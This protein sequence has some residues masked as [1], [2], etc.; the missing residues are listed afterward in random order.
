MEQAIRIQTLRNEE[1]KTYGEIEEDLGVSSKTIAKALLRPQEFV[2]GYQRQ[3]PVPRPVLGPFLEKI[4]E[5]LKGKDWAKE[6]GRK[7][8]RTARWVYRKIKKQGYE[9]AESTVRAYIREKF[10]KPRPACPIEHRP[11]DEVQF[12]F[13]QY[14]VRV[15]GSVQTI[16]FAGSVFPYSTR[17][18]LFAYPAERQECLFDAIERTYQKAGGIS[19]RSTLDNTKLAVARVLQGHRREETEAYMRFRV[20]LGLTPRF[21][22]VA[23]GWEKGHVE[24]TV[25]WA[26]R[27]VFLDLEVENWEELQKV[28]DDAC[29]EDAGTRRHG[30]D[31]KLVQELFE[32]ERQFLRPLPY[33]G[34]RSYRRVRAQVSPGGLVYVDGTRYSV[35]IRLRGRHVRIQLYWDELVMTHDHEEV[36]CHR[37]DWKG[38]GEHYQVEHYLAL[39]ERAPALLD[40]GKP[41]TRMPEWLRRTREALRDDKGLVQLLLAVDA[42]RYSLAELQEA[43]L[44]ALQGRCVTRALIEQRAILRRS[45]GAEEV[46]TLEESECGTL[47]IH[48][49]EVESPEVYDEILVSAAE[50]VA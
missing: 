18:M 45:G 20:L 25:G 11:G 42:G 37:R 9:G 47:S 32:E 14:P 41:F 6:K 22:S 5:L 21:T 3:G 16:H 13:G 17:R 2:E 19:Q 46:Q 7:V 44:E 29:D 40:H 8:R 49:F 35:P 10:K 33:V 15:G 26:K 28:L 50:E 4:E 48:R 34:R 24:G 27:Q 31:N 36:A 39:L 1:N 43:C 30:P 23:A 12:D 38:R